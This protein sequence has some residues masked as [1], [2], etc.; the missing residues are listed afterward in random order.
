MFSD[1]AHS[2]YMEIYEGIR[3]YGDYCEVQ[4]DNTVL[5]MLSLMMIIRAFSRPG[6]S[7]NIKGDEDFCYAIVIKDYYRALRGE[8]FCP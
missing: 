5:A 6:S 3:T 1:S 7:A 4:K 8:E 2:A